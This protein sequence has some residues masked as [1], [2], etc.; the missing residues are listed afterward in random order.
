MNKIVKKLLRKPPRWAAWILLRLCRR[1]DRYSLMDDLEIEYSDLAAERGC[2]L[3]FLWYVLQV[4]SVIPELIFLHILWSMTMFKN[5]LRIAFRNIWKHKGISLLNIT[6]LAVGITVF[7]LI[8]LYVQFE[9]SFDRYHTNADR[10]YR[11]SQE[12]SYLNTYDAR[13]SAPL[14][15]VMV[16]EFPEVEA[17]TRLVKFNEVLVYSDS[18]GFF[19]NNFLFGDLQIFKLFSFKLIR[20]DVNMALNDPYSVVISRQMSQK[21]FGMQDPVGQILKCNVLTCDFE[22]MVTGVFEDIPFNSHFTGDFIVS[23]ETQEKILGRGV[24]GWGNNT[25]YTYVLLRKETDSKALETKFLSTDFTKYSEGYDLHNYS[26]QP[27]TDIYLR[28]Q[29]GGEIEP[30]SDMKTI[31]LFSFIAVLI[32]AIAC[33]NTVNLGTAR[34]ASR[35]KEVGLRKVIGAQRSQLIRQFLCESM[36]LTISAFLIAIGSIA[37]LLPWFRMF[38]ERPIHFHPFQNVILFLVFIVIIFLTGILS[39]AYPAWMLSA[40][41][42]VSLFRKFSLDH[43][44]GLT[45]RN[46]LVVFQ[47][48]VSIVLIIC[49]L[50]AKDQF[51]FLRNRDMGYNRNQIITL[52]IQDARLEANLQSLRTELKRSNNILNASISACLLDN[53]RFR[54]DAARPKKSN[55]QNYSFYTIDT[56]YNFVDL[57]GMQ[58]IRGR[59]FSSDYIADQNGA[60]LI[61]ETAA[62]TLE[63][64]DPLGRELMLG[65]NRIG[66]IVGIVK[67]FHIQSMY[68]PVEP[69]V[70]YLKKDSQMWYW[71]HLSVKIRPEDIPSTLNFIQE[72]L[73]RFASNYPFEYTFFDEVF[74]RTFKV[75]Q[76]IANLF[77]VFA[78]I[79]IL[80]GCLGLFGLASFSVQKRAKEIGIRKVLGASVPGVIVLVGQEFLKWVLLANVI[81]WPVGYFVMHRWLQNFAYRTT[82]TLDSFILSAL[83]ALIIASFT[84]CIQTLEAATANP[85]DCIRYE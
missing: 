52:P 39:G 28:S 85:V 20:G 27:L 62:N 9:L 49:T 19:E 69:L 34:T 12:I 37:L 18:H 80:I 26:L 2:M 60:F 36:I 5:Y 24:L 64:D 8:F 53:V 70:I 6:G 67:D 30:I 66:Q 21:Y 82:I 63:W 35:V 38:V 29:L 54:M 44:K 71:R 72:T 56:D 10:I 25:Y 4:L 50:I 78:S 46:I 13:T 40:F 47:F 43:R 7:I 75:D 61:N 84:V 3:A 17:A 55:G 22:L 41:R 79:A 83:A 51:R 31:R 74:D 77:S 33:I 58:I 42:P 76:K 81:A 65:G 57:Y 45:L 32:M 48:S 23:F 59:K 73:Q 1:G 15:D 11:V 16:Q 14:A 68:Q